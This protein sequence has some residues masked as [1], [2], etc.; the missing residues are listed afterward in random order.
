MSKFRVVLIFPNGEAEEQDELFDTEWEAEDYGQYLVSC[1][2]TGAE[3][4]E[5]SNPFDYPMDEFED[6][7][8][9]V[10]EE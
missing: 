6:Y 10:V 1:A 7:E 9:F 3:V 5:L 4:L 8:Y 2:R